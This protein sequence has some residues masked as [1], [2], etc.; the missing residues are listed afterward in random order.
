MTHPRIWTGR[1]ELV[2]AT[3][4]M[5]KADLDQ[6]AELSRLLDA[7]LPDDWPPP[8]TDRSGLEWTLNS[9]ADPE[10]TGFLLWYWVCR[11]GPVRVLIG[12]GGFKGKPT[13][14]G[15]VEVGYS[16][17]EEFHRCGY[18]TEA[19]MALV[20]FAF[21]HPLVR[22]VIAETYPELAPSIRVLQKCGFACIGPAAEPDVIRFER[23]RPP[24]TEQLR[25][26][27]HG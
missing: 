3:E 27:S 17:V 4:P 23:L 5:V 7:R 10:Q 15:A 20:D 13:Q 19:V 22:R 1:L 18:A 21:D 24:S 6:R 26:H 12:E 25:H 8:L 14:D 16:V 2:S 11:E 9:M